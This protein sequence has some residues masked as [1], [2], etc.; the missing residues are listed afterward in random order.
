[1]NK[2]N[3]NNRQDAI[4]KL[5]D[6]IKATKA[7]M[8]TTVAD[9][10]GTLRSRPMSTQQVEFDGDLWFLTNIDSAK[11]DE[12]GREHRVNISYADS[13]DNRY[14]SVSGAA[15]VSGDEAKIKSLWSP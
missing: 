6:L 11:T 1:M 5:G 15:R 10:E 14:I 9:E 2:E 12:I 8:L 7:G 13:R 4:R 3:G